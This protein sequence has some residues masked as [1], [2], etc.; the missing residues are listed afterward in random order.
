MDSL[1]GIQPQFSSSFAVTSVTGL[2]MIKRFSVRKKYK[3]SRKKLIRILSL[4][5]LIKYQT[6][7]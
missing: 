6:E 2:S 7:G 5:Y 4:Y 3:T 1:M